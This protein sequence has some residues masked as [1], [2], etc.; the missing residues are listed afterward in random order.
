MPKGEQ[1]RILTDGKNHR[2]L[3]TRVDAPD[4]ASVIHVVE[5][6]L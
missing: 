3:G 4:S 2:N 6:F 1:V 5:L